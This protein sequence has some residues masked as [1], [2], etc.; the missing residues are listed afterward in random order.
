MVFA[1]DVESAHFILAGLP[2]IDAVA[3][4]GGTPGRMQPER[5]ARD[6]LHGIFNQFN[7]LTAVNHLRGRNDP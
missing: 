1:M 3:M 5:R 6:K 4:V 2:S 7:S